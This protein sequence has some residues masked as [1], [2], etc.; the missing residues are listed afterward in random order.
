MNLPV[1]VWRRTTRA[2]ELE[3]ILESCQGSIIH[4]R[5]HVGEYC[6]IKGH[7]RHLLLLQIDLTTSYGLYRGYGIDRAD[8]NTALNLAQDYIQRNTA[9]TRGSILIA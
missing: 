4:S 1:N 2:A 8:L 6:S 3:V 9:P 7:P 5:P